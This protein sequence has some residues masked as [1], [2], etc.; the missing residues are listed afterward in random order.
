MTVE[1][2][3]VESSNIGTIDVQSRSARRPGRARQKHWEYM[4]PFGLGE[5]TAL[6]FPGESAGILKDCDDLWGSERV[7]VAYGQGVA[8]T[9]IQLVSAVNA[10]ANDGMYVRPAARR[11][12][13]SAPTASSP[14]PQPSATH[15]VDPARDRRPGAAHDAGRGVR[16]GAPANS[17]RR[18]IEN[19]S[20]AGKTGTGSSRRP[21]AR[22]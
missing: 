10:I 13:P 9:S 3:L 20:V 12:A 1:Q 18:G 15:E 7:T 17:P 19:F 16:P 4:R 11:A 21:T 2:I 6:D 22:T 8:S 5:K 14:T